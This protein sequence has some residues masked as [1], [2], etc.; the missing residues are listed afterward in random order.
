MIFLPRSFN[1]VRAITRGLAGALVL[2]ALIPAEALACACGCSVFDVGSTALLPKEGDHGGA[3]YFEWDHSDQNTNWSGLSKAPAA[4]NGDKHILTDWYVVGLNYMVNR[5][6]GFN[7]R[8]PTANR[9]FLTDNGFN[10]IGQPETP[11]IERYHVS[12]LGD[13]ELTG[14]Y[15]GFSDDMSKGLIFGLKLPTGD[16]RAYGFDRDSNVGTGSTDLILGGFWRGLITGDNAWQYFAQTK[17]LLPIWTHSE[18]D[19]TFGADAGDYRPGWQ[20]D[21]AFGIT[22]N[23]WYHVGPFDKVAPLLQVI[24]SHREPDSGAAADP[25]DS[26]FDRI[27]ISP[28]ID[29]TKVLDD[30]NNRT[31]KLYGDIEIPVYQ[32]TN[33][34]QLVS[35]FLSKI[36][37]A[38]TF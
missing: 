24:V 8:I 29:F 19:P 13:I 35:P 4:N 10:G 15:T 9:S 21:T 12:T 38:Y 34:N 28:G 22:Y 7:V 3:V 31:F 11:D 36:V 27:F 14:M 6:W 30:P 37:A 1:P 26:G 17:F 25:A 2:C 18:A 33:G 20:L 5:D 32:R 16:W 23:N